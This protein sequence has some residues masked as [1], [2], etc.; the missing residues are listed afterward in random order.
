MGQTKANTVAA[1]VWS[2]GVLLHYMLTG[3]LPSLP[4]IGCGGKSII[5]DPGTS[6]Q[7]LTTPVGLV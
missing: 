5:P 2:C 1:D 6:S 4:R 3:D 7:V